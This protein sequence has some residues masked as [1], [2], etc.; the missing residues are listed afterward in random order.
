[1]GAIE[2]PN[3]H[4]AF[5]W[6]VPDPDA[7]EAAVLGTPIIS[8]RGFEAYNPNTT[9]ENPLGGF[10]YL[11]TGAYAMKLEDGADLLNCITSAT[12]QDPGWIQ[13][14]VF[15]QIPALLGPGY[16]DGKTLVLGSVDFALQPQDPDF[17][18]MVH[19]YN[20]ADDI[21]TTNYPFT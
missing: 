21:E 8:S 4:W 11:A 6:V 5:A 1:V 17:Q 18:V 2:I 9:I 13:G 12:T 3:S 10:T 16:A 14:A 15:P 19:K 20:E 7:E